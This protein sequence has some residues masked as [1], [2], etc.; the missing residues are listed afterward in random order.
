MSEQPNGW[1][2]D[3]QRWVA[4]AGGASGGGSRRRQW[5]LVAGA[6]FLVALLLLASAGAWLGLKRL[7]APVLGGAHA[8]PSAAASTGGLH[9]SPAT[10]AAQAEAI[11]AFIPVAEKFVEE[12]RGLRFKS[13]VAVKFAADAEFD[14]QLLDISDKDAKDLEIMGKLLRAL[15]L[16][17]PGVDL[18]KAQRSL[19]TTSV[20][21]Y[22]DPESKELTVRGADLTPRTKRTLVH[23][24]T[25]ALQDQHFNLGKPP[26]RGAGDESGEAFLGLVEGDAVRIEQEYVASMPADEQRQAMAA[27]ST[28]PGPDVPQVLL[29]ILSFPYTVGL[30]F[31]KAL[32]GA[33]GQAGVDAAFTNRPQT[34]AQL[35][36][37]QRFLNGIGP[38]PVQAPTADAVVVDKGVLG[39]LGLVLILEKPL[40]AGKLSP[41]DALEAV[42]GWG[43]D[44][45]VMWDRGQQSCVRARF[46]AD[47]AG[48]AVSLL[49]SMQAYAA[50][51]SGSTLEGTGPVTL[52]SCA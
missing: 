26:G 48:A 36:Q 16:I 40:A 52:T 32:L 3:G 13:Q 17:E 31:V 47:G 43:G 19:L 8:R 12:H 50:G 20:I 15:G 6:L 30:T 44:Q 18:I 11:R 37:P 51:R 10:A 42:H 21:G 35:L 46:V 24:L 45:Y 22:Y 34:T 5:W 14:K 2:W 49:R 41:G 23:E 33:K 25:H 4:A 38:I 1:R 29:E 39:E 28:G 7:N 9:S 27:P